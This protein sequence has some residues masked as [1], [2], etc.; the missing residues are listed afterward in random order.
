M[1]TGTKQAQDMAV[2]TATATP[3]AD[4]PPAAPATETPEATPVPA[5]PSS[6]PARAGLT[7]DTALPSDTGAPRCA[8]SA[9]HRLDGRLP[10]GFVD[11]LALVASELMTNAVR[12][13]GPA[14]DTKLSVWLTGDRLVIEV[15]SAGAPF[16]RT[17]MNARP[18]IAGGFGLRVVDAL[19]DRWWVE[20][21][22]GNRVVCEFDSSS[23]T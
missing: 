10:A 17:A 14:P 7:I 12:H 4:G 2:L 13:A 22:G 3:A 21:D 18:G 20:H 23:W 1:R 15:S 9:I 11:R 16:D 8:R 19:A 6:P 5:R